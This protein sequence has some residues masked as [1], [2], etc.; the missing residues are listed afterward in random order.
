MKDPINEEIHKHREEHARQ[1]NYD[2]RAICDDLR[3]LQQSA[4][5]K[6]AG[7]LPS[8][9]DPRAAPKHPE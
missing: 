8:G 4:N 6:G 7:C 1:F 5:L 2:V 9:S 3:A